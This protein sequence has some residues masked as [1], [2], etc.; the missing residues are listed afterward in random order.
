MDAITG[1]GRIGRLRYFGTSLLIGLG[2][3]VGLAVAY[4]LSGGPDPDGGLPALGWVVIVGWIWLSTTNTIR[5]LHDLNFSGLMVLVTFIPLI[6]GLFTL[7]LLFAPGDRGDNRFGRPYG[8]RPT[9][10][11][12]E[13]RVQAAQIRAEAAAAYSERNG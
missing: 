13:H 9:L 4:V 7:Y 6:G 2:A 10:G 12:A 1:R 11:L 8:T 3:T 5:R